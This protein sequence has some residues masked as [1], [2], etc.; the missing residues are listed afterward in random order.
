VSLQYL[1]R[2]T[3]A[4]LDLPPGVV[5]SPPWQYGNL[6]EL[7]PLWPLFRLDGVLGLEPM[8]ASIKAIHATMDVNVNAVHMEKEALESQVD[9]R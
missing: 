1:V 9:I 4:H 2:C 8:E 7:F 5:S 6:G 3:V